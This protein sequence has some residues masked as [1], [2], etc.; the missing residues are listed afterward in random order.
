M[1]DGREAEILEKYDYGRQLRLENQ[2]RKEPI[3]V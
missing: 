1:R 2:Y 3:E